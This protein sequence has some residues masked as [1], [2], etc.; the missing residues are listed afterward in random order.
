MKTTIITAAFVVWALSLA[1]FAEEA[2][3]PSSTVTL[4]QAELAQH[5]ERVAATAV[6]NYMARQISGNADPADAKIAAAFH[7]K[8]RP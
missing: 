2:I 3:V 6:L 7:L 4:T 1:A 8:P 5:D